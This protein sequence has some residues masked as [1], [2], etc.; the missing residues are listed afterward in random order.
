MCNA[1]GEDEQGNKEGSDG[2]GTIEA[3]ERE[4]ER[5][6]DDRDGAEGVIYHLKRRGFHVQIVLTT[7]EHDECGNIS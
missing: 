3:S 2:I 7:A 4:H 6:H 5:A 1:R